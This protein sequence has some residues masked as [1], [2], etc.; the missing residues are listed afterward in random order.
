MIYGWTTYCIPAGMTLFESPVL[1]SRSP[2]PAI[3]F[4]CHHLRLESPSPRTR[5][6]QRELDVTKPGNESCA[7]NL[8]AV[9]PIPRR[10]RNTYAADALLLSNWRRERMK[11]HVKG[12]TT[13]MAI[14]Q[15]A[16][17]PGT[18]GVGANSRI[19]EQLQDA[20]RARY[21]LRAGPGGKH[22][23]TSRL[24]AICSLE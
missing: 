4:R 7:P 18:K 12:E 11:R 9:E 16:N 8:S 21:L 3:P 2:S 13:N 24:C 10:N 15:K 20:V 5:M 14:C 19:V 23:E 22:E 6:S 17:E 1:L